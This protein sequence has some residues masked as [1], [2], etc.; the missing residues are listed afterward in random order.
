MRDDRAHLR[1]HRRQVHFPRTN[2]SRNIYGIDG[3]TGPNFRRVE[4][5]RRDQRSGVFTQAS[6]L[7]VS[8][9]PTRTSVVL[10]GKYFWKTF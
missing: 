3:V 1:F 2:G 4:S 10:R 6:V 8:S 5:D 9:Y 7:T